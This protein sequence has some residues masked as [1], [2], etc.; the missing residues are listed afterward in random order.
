M[1][2]CLRIGRDDH[3]LGQR[4]AE[5]P[6]KGRGGGLAAHN[7]HPWRVSSQ[8]QALLFKVLC[9]LVLL[10]ENPERQ[11]LDRYFGLLVNALALV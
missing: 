7:E 11:E 9:D 1:G 5:T 6:A 8:L 10:V 3:H 4:V 2:G